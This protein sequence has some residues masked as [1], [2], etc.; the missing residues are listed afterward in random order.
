MT[1]E[2]V[3]RL[4]ELPRLIAHERDANES[5]RLV[6]ELQ[7]LTELQWEELR[8]RNQKKSA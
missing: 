3:R 8:S 4:Y 5:G 7:E 6:T 1:P 2:Q